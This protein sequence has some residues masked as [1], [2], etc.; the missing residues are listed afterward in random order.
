MAM[1]AAITPAD[2]WFCD[3]RQSAR[4]VAPPGRS[5]RTAVWAHTPRLDFGVDVRRFWGRYWPHGLFSKAEIGPCSFAPPEVRKKLPTCHGLL[6]HGVKVPAQAR[7]H[8][9]M[10]LRAAASA[11]SGFGWVAGSG[12]RG[13]CSQ[14]FSC[15]CDCGSGCRRGLAC[16]SVTGLVCFNGR[17]NQ[18]PRLQL[19][20]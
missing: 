5:T 6:K 3:H 9:L 7:W 10:A 4:P 15:R 18:L 11:R 12:C 17:A 1:T 8:V 20:V 19:A 14:G 13:R 2:T 16:R